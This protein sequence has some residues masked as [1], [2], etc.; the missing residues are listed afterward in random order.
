MEIQSE[1][2]FIFAFGFLLGLKHATDADHVV[3]IASIVGRERNVWQSIWLGASWGL[4]HSLPLLCVGA[5]VL[6]WRDAANELLEPISP[7]LEAIVGVMLIYLG[8][9]SAWNVLRG[10]VHLHRHDHGERAH[11]H[12]HASHSQTDVHARAKDGHNNFFLFGRPVFRAKSFAIG[13]VH[14]L[15]GSAA[16]TV[17]VLPD[18]GPASVGIA[19]LLL[20][21]VGTMLSM[22]VLTL[23]VALPFRASASR[24]T[25]SRALVLTAS[26]MS[27]IVGAILISDS[28]GGTELM[29]F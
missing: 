4:G 7:Y 12:V 3:A 26:A 11:V 27:G 19:Y 6:I 5:M 8:F 24:A 18:I 2:F 10:K 16:V 21:S 15:A 20:F 22:S 14:G 29:P 1:I 9:S 28:I 25:L 13:I 23:V 17:A